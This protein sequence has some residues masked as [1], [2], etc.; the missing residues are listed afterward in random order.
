L[1]DTAE[2][3]VVDKT[4][5]ITFCIDDL[6]EIQS[7]FNERARYTDDTSNQMA[8]IINGCYLAEVAKRAQRL[9]CSRFRRHCTQWSDPFGSGSV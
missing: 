5:V 7:N 4:P 3:L 2:S 1:T 8:N 6:D 9:G